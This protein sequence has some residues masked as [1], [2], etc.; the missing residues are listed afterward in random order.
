MLFNDLLEILWY[1]VGVVELLVEVVD[2]C[3]MVNNVFGNV[4]YLVE[5]VGIELLVDLFVE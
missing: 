3:I 1:D 4:G 2:L 5:E